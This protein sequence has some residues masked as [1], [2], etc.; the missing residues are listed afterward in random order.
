M[1]WDSIFGWKKAKKPIIDSI[2]VITEDFEITNVN[3]DFNK[4]DISDSCQTI[5]NNLAVYL[6][7]NPNY[8]IM[9][10]GYTDNIGSKKYNKDLSEKRALS[11]MYYLT[12]KS[13]YRSRMDYLGYNYENPIAD[14]NSGTGRAKNRRVE[15]TL[16]EPTAKSSTKKTQ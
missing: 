12:S 13:V 3:F 5:L 4:F 11:V 9:L 6:N 15:I 2:P 8:K 16:V 7:K 10:I 14:N 1:D